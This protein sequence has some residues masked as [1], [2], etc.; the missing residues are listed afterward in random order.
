MTVQRHFKE[1]FNTLSMELIHDEF[2][3]QMKNKSDDGSIHIDRFSKGIL[4]ED[5]I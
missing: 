2:I 1:H 4:I 5:V 3:N